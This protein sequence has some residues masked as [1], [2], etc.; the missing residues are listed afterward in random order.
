M[1]SLSREGH[2]DALPGPLED[3]ETQRNI[4][5]HEKCFSFLGAVCQA[6]SI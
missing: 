1:R 6:P 3:M 5:L 2:S 4:P